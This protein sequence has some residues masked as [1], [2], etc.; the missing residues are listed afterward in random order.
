ME[1]WRPPVLCEAI[2]MCATSRQQRVVKRE[3]NSV[4]I[5]IL[6]ASL[7]W[8]YEECHWQVDG[9]DILSDQ[10]RDRVTSLHQRDSQARSKE[11]KMRRRKKKLYF[12]LV[13]FFKSVTITLSP[14]NVRTVGIIDAS[15]TTQLCVGFRDENSGPHVWKASYFL[16][17]HVSSPQ[18]LIFKGM[19]FYTLIL[20]TIK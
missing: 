6:A 15:F 9:R 17:E 7:S 14:S 2:W 4:Q 20:Q 19:Y 11:V 3:W 5:Y 12:C 13:H 16:T 8:S 10:L 18:T 1:P